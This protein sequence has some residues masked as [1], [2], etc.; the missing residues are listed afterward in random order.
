MNGTET[1][2]FFPKRIVYFVQMSNILHPIV[3]PILML[4]GL[5]LT[6]PNQNT[7]IQIDY[8]KILWNFH[9]LVTT[10]SNIKT[11][12]FFCL[13]LLLINPSLGRLN[14]LSFGTLPKW[15]RASVQD[16]TAFKHIFKSH[17]VL[18]TEVMNKKRVFAF[19][20]RDWLFSLHQLGA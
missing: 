8:N 2:L 10:S 14:L 1:F 3:S 5:G 7:C 11:C 6:E 4:Q 12:L 18:N 19:L 13:F 16:T 20:L 17:P 9:C 15:G